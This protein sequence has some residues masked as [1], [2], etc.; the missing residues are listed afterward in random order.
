MRNNKMKRMP[1][2]TN[3][4]Q[5]E[6]LMAAGYNK[7][8]D[9]L[10]GLYDLVYANIPFMGG[11][12]WRINEEGWYEHTEPY[13][14]M[15]IARMLQ[16]IPEFLDAKYDEV[17]PLNFLIIGNHCLGYAYAIQEEEKDFWFKYFNKTDLVENLVDCLIWLKEKGYVR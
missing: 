16:I 2:G 5:T 1:I 7:K 11:D 14:S 13:P 9:I 8:E 15:S 10:N 3:K 4:E 17:E 6:R 12:N